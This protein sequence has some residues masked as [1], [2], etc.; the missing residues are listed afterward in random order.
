MTEKNPPSLLRSRSDSESHPHRSTISIASTFSDHST[1]SA[2]SSRSSRAFSSSVQSLASDDYN[3]EPSPTHP[4]S[5]MGAGRFWATRERRQPRFSLQQA[6]ERIRLPKDFRRSEPAKPQ[7]PVALRSSDRDRVAEAREWIETQCATAGFGDLD[8]GKP[9]SPPLS[10]KKSSISLASSIMTQSAT[11][12]IQESDAPTSAE[13]LQMRIDVLSDRIAERERKIRTREQL[14]RVQAEEEGYAPRVPSV[15]VISERMEQD[16][17]KSIQIE[18]DSRS[19]I[20]PSILEETEDQDELPAYSNPSSVSV[21]DYKKY[22]PPTP[23][24]PAFSSYQLI[25]P[26]QMDILDRSRSESLTPKPYLHRPEGT[27][28]SS[29]MRVNEAF[30]AAPEGATSLKP[31]NR[32]NHQR[33]LSAPADRPG[34]LAV[35]SQQS[36]RG[37]SVSIDTRNISPTAYSPISSAVTTWDSST[38]ETT[39]AEDVKNMFLSASSARSPPPPPPPIT[40]PTTPIVYCDDPIALSPTEHPSDDLSLFSD[41]ESLAGA[42]RIKPRS[43]MSNIRRNVSHASQAPI[44]VSNATLQ[45]QGTSYLAG[46]ASTPAMPAWPN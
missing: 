26:G 29:D 5:Q 31:P 19:A 7:Q 34:Q 37:R 18:M 28:N 15:E 30:R 45:G 39:P 1:N 25:E 2:P 11:A 21:A 24:H 23:P 3:D 36:G 32:P 8:L 38:A 14:E 13:D 20:N 44:P 4:L 22:R 27:P 33:T 41:L 42:Y 6:R 10:S 40:V 46:R 43:S 35:D 9:P 12:S 16:P 17:L